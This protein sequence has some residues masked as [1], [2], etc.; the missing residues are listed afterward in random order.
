MFPQYSRVGPVVNMDIQTLPM[1]LLVMLCQRLHYQDILSLSLVSKQFHSV[2][3][4]PSLWK[5]F[6]LTLGR[7]R[8]RELKRIL[9]DRRFSCLEELTLAGCEILDTHVRILLRSNVKKIKGR[10]IQFSSVSGLNSGLIYR[11]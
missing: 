3:Q 2:C 11:L 9:E 8:I 10:C 5:H 6:N 1:E 7:G 4:H